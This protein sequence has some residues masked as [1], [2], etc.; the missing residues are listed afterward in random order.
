MKEVA[1]SSGQVSPL[2]VAWLETLEPTWK[3]FSQEPVS[4]VLVKS[5]KTENTR[6]FNNPD[7]LYTSTRTHV[8]HSME[9]VLV[10]GSP[11][12]GF[13]EFRELFTGSLV[14]IFS[15]TLSDTY[16]PA[17]DRDKT[18]VQSLRRIAIDGVDHG[19]VEIV[20]REEV[21]ETRQFETSRRGA[22]MPVFCA[23]RLY[24]SLKGMRVDLP[25]EVLP[26]SW[27]PIDAYVRGR[28]ELL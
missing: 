22:L 4:R 20:A 21:W 9:T 26:L 14:P 5:H 17:G 16:H 6:H 8:K 24:V 7:G 11:A 27:A 3:G 25:S 19:S 1:T 23:E 28:Q 12:R 13:M 10:V 18:G 2:E 15:V